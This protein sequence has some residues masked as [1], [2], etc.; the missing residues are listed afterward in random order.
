MKI[1]INESEKEPKLQKPPWPKALRE[2]YLKVPVVEASS[3]GLITACTSLQVSLTSALRPGKV[4]PTRPFQSYI[5]HAFW[6]GKSA[7][8]VIMFF[9]F[10]QQTP[11]CPSFHFSRVPHH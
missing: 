3:Y 9:F 2:G 10:H 6:Q 5:H 4:P 11:K 8:L 1:A 7:Y